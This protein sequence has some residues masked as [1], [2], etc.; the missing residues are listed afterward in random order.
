MDTPRYTPSYTPTYTPRY[1]SV[2]TLEI[3]KSMILYTT[4]VNATLR[5]HISTNL[6]TT[7]RYVYPMC[8]KVKHVRNMSRY[9]TRCRFHR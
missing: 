6:D 7:Y 3:Y 5:F 9:H 8:P 4:Q 1:T 2:Y